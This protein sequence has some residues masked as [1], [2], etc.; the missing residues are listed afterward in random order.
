MMPM[1]IIIA[2]LSRAKS[3]PQPYLSYEEE[4]ELV[5]HLVKCDETGYP[6]MKDEV[7]GIVRQADHNKRGAKFAKEF[8]GKVVGEIC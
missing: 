8:I 5:A 2:V 1:C 6:K 7:I 4:Q 3:G